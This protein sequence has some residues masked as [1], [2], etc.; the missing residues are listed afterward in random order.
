MV[1]VVPA[2]AALTLAC[3]SPQANASVRT[4]DCWARITKDSAPA[5]APP[6]SHGRRRPN[7]ETSCGRRTR[8]ASG[9]ATTLTAAP[10]P[11]IQ[12]SAT[13]LPS[14]PATWSA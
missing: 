8:P 2:N 7:F 6:N 13:S 14:A 1:A 10:T 5:S 12:A 4:V 9:F 11:V 3:T